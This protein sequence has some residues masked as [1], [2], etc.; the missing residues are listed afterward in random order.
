[1]KKLIVIILTFTIILTGCS[2][3]NNVTETTQPENRQ[4][5]QNDI[6]DSSNT[7]SNIPDNINTAGSLFEKGY[8]D[9]QGTI[10]ND[11]TIRM[12]LYPLEKDIV[13]SYFYESQKKEIDLK[14]KAGGEDILLYEYDETGKNTGVFRGSMD[15]VDKIEGTWTSADNKKNYPFTLSLISNLPGAEYG[16][17]YA[18]AALKASDQDV[19]NFINKVQDYVMNNKKEQLSKQISYPITVKID[20]KATTIQN[21]D[22]FIKH[23]DKIFYLD[24]KQVIGSASTK[25]MFANWQGIMFGTGSSNIWINEL[26]AT[27]GNQKLMITAI[28]H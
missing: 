15:T 19:E 11:I 10:N 16:K 12:S 13:G 6:G 17:R 4:D 1:M 21:K 18:I 27:D 23:Y 2:A 20:G 14:G 8:Y 22:D 3:N 28:N 26:T 25:Y 24:Y 9:Y 7:N 5:L